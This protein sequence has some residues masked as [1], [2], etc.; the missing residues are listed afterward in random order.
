MSLRLSCL[1]V[2][3]GTCAGAQRQGK[4]ALFASALPSRTGVPPLYA[5]RTVAGYIIPILLR[6]IV[7]MSLPTE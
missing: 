6:D 2:L 5:A 7:P 4:C 3:P 1:L